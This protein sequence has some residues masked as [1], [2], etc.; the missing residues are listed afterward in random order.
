MRVRD[1]FVE[2]IDKKEE[3]L[4]TVRIKSIR[5]QIK[6][7]YK[8]LRETC[9]IIEPCEFMLIWGN[10]Q[11]CL[12]CIES[13]VSLV[14]D[15][16]VGSANAL[17]RQIYE[18]LVWA[19]A[20]MNSDTVTLKTLN[21]EFYKDNLSHRIT[22]TDILKAARIE[23]SGSYSEHEMKEMGKQMYHGYSLL[24]HASNIS[25]QAPYKRDD[26]YIFLNDCLSEVSLL[27]DTFLLVY[28]QY[29]KV[30]KTPFLDECTLSKKDQGYLWAARVHAG[31][32]LH[33]IPQ[34]HKELCAMQNIHRTF[35]QVAFI[36]KWH[37]DIN[38]LYYLK[39]K[40][41]AVLR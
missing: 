34:Y 2:T 14:S 1:R 6:A 28:Y 30:L 15:G 35:L 17:L 3:M 9:A 26:F 23:D 31:E 37:I 25:Q 18:F 8:H 20:G 21:A 36:A 29:L 39:I 7:L 38:K 32:I 4:L 41:P 13:C 22:A 11:R 40:F 5:K 12:V 33:R 27:F 19:K 10:L 24:T 16:Y